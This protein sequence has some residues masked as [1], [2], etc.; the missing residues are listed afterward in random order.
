MAWLPGKTWSIL[1]ATV[2]ALILSVCLIFTSAQRPRTVTPTEQSTKGSTTKGK[3]IKLG[4]RDDFQVALNRALPGDTI[5]LQAGATYSGQF[6]LPQKKGAQY[7]TIESSRSSELPEGVRVSPRQAPLMAKVQANAVAPAIKAEINSH[8]YKFI[9]VEFTTSGAGLSYGIVV[10]GD[11][12]TSGPQNK[13]EVVPHH[14]VFD[15]CYVHGQPKQNV[16]RGIALNSAETEILNSYIDEIHWAGTDAQAVGG[17]NGPGPYRII[18]NHLEAAGENVM[19]GGARPAIPGLIPSDIEVR[20]NYVYK[21]TRWRESDAAYDGSK[22]TVKNLL[23]L[24]NARRVTIDGNVFENN[25]AQAQ[26][27]FAILFNCIDDSGS[28]ARIEDVQF[29][30]N[31]VRRSGNAFN[32]RGRDDTG[33]SASRITIRNNLFDEISSQ[34][35]GSGILFQ[36]LRGA[37]DVTIEYNTAINNG[38]ILLMD[39]E[40]MNN[41]SFQ[42]NIVHHNAYGVFGNGGGVG[43]AALNRY[44]TKWAFTRNVIIAIPPELSASQYPPNNYFPTSVEQVGFVNRQSR[45]YRLNQNSRFKGKAVDGGD[46][47][48]NMDQLPQVTQSDGDL[49]IATAVGQQTGVR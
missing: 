9:G 37:S 18:N 3:V 48:C 6:S 12:D 13:L 34:L 28:W 47:G 38:S 15:R 36:L 11:G 22:W 26:A 42:N 27:G 29:T 33:A 25:W 40:P 4:P 23:E 20:K 30:N 21:P 5:V 41:L 35:G 32:I 14:L 31:I 24:K 10:L 45:D 2:S 43:S 16:Q 1:I 17:W 19:F 46:I 39:G 44:A 8:H 49:L 7:I